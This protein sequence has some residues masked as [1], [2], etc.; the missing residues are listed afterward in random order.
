LIFELSIA[1]HVEIRHEPYQRTRAKRGAA[2]P[3]NYRNILDKGETASRDGGVGFE[4][5]RPKVYA[6]LKPVSG[7]VG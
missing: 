1:L 5:D 3:Q 2:T 6:I 4:M 7:F